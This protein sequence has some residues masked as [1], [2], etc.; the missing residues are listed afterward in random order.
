MN[1]VGWV[2]LVALGALLMVLRFEPMFVD[3]MAGGVGGF[4]IGIGLFKLID[5]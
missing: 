5:A 2:A 4:C 3:L 1:I